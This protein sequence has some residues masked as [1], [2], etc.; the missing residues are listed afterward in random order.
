MTAVDEGAHFERDFYLQEFRGRTL[1]IACPAGLLRD[2]DPLA[3]VVQV[4]ARNDTQVIVISSRRDRLAAAVGDRILPASTGQ[5]ETAVWRAL[6]QSSRLGILAGG[7]RPF[8]EQIREVALRLGLFKLV[9]I[10]PQGGMRASHGERL[11]FVH[12]D[13]LRQLL[14]Q[15]RR[16]GRERVA[17]LRAVDRLLTGGIQAVNVC[18]LTGLRE[19][20]F[21]YPGSG[22]LFTRKRYIAVRDLGLDDFDAAYD[23]I[24]RGVEEGY[25]APRPARAIDQI[26]VSG[27]GAFVEGSHLAGIGA[28]LPYPEIRAGEIA[29]LYTLTRFLGEGVGQHLVRYALRQ[30]RALRFRSIFACTTQERVAA[31]FERQGFEPISPDEL[32]ARKWRRYDQRRRRRVQCYRRELPVRRRRKAPAP[33]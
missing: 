9:W 33:E 29:S 10:D 13:E 11:S 7:R 19:E 22:T 5:L 8:T 1:G 16:I 6:R 26:L 14:S 4:L 12:Q 20:L 23:L 31:F 28:L 17:L 3:A 18:T 24:S 32:P 30:A 2:A 27:F 21:T 15:P 25:L